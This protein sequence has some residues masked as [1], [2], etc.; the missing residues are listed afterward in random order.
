[1]SFSRP[2]SS[3]ELKIALD[4]A[5]ARGIVL[6]ASAGNDGK[7]VLVYPAAYDNVIG[8]A[9]TA[10]D[11]TRSWFSNYGSRLVTLAAPGQ[12]VI[13]TYPG[14]SFAATMGTSFSAPI[15]SGGAALLVGLQ[16]SA[17]PNQVLYALS[18]AK[19]LTTDMGYGRADLYQSVKAGRALWPWAPVS[20]VPQSC[21]YDGVDWSEAP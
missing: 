19:R 17:S 21:T 2:T 12:G 7:A 18:F 10:N 9:S 14:A 15:V 4:F 3:R 5:S 13:T 20:A 11:D 6:V 8:V 1:M 16:G